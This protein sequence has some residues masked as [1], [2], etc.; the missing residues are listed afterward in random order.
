M[1]GTQP[2]T[3]RELSM[4]RSSIVIR[5]TRTGP[6]CSVQLAGVKWD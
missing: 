3:E 2:G 5:T 1:S 6:G 4:L